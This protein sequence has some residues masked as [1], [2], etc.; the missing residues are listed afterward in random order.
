MTPVIFHKHG[1]RLFTKF[2]PYFITC[3]WL[4]SVF[5]NFVPEDAGCGS[6]RPNLAYTILGPET[7]KLA[8]PGPGLGQSF[9]FNCFS[10]FGQCNVSSRYSISCLFEW[11]VAFACVGTSRHDMEASLLASTFPKV[12]LYP[13]FCF[14]LFWHCSLNMRMPPCFQGRT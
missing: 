9:R 3:C 2:R 1:S 12:V 5:S 8:S 7:R 10:R 14:R 13:L 4:Q 11:C 6:R